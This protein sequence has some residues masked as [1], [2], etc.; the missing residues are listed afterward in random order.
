MAFLMMME[1]SK[2]IVEIS[3]KSRNMDYDFL[4]DFPDNERKGVLDI[5]RKGRNERRFAHF[6]ILGQQTLAFLTNHIKLELEIECP[7]VS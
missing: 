4:N 3:R 7:R 5:E 1:K 2:C 6:Q